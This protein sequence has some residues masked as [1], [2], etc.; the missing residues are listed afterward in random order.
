MGL[1]G[2]ILLGHAVVKHAVKSANKPTTF[3]RI[4][5]FGDEMIGVAE[6]ISYLQEQS[7]LNK[8][9]KMEKKQEKSNKKRAKISGQDT[10]TIDEEKN[11]TITQTTTDTNTSDNFEMPEMPEMPDFSKFIDDIERFAKSDS[12]T[13]KHKGEKTVKYEYHSKSSTINDDVE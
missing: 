2:K 9:R 1:L 5:N 8:L 6:G 11:I 13:S 7:K 10:P 4:R 12:A 3:D